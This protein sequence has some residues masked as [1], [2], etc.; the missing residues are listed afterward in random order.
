MGGLM[1]LVLPAEGLKPHPLQVRGGAASKVPMLSCLPSAVTSPF[2]E[3]GINDQA[4]FPV[5][6]RDLAEAFT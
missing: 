2:D 1:D 6:W 5:W 4:G 3:W